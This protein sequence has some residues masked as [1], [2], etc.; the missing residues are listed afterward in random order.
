M[1]F[2]SA[3]TVTGVT[4]KNNIPLSFVFGSKRNVTVTLRKFTEA[5][6]KGKDPNNM[7]CLTIINKEPSPQV[8][9]L[10]ENLLKGNYGNDYLESE[11]QLD[12]KD[13]RPTVKHT[14]KPSTIP[15]ELISFSQ[16]ITRQ[17]NDYAKRTIQV[18]RWRLNASS[19]QNPFLN[20]W[21]PTWSFDGKTWTVLPSSEIMHASIK[22]DMLVA[23]ELMPEIVNLIN[24]GSDEPLAH[25]LLREAYDH[26]GTNPR[27]ALLTGIAAAEIGV[28]HLLTKLL[29]DT[30]W[31][32]ENL[33][34]P[35]IILILTQYFPQLLSHRKIKRKNLPVPQTI[36][37]TL[38]DGVALRNSVAH[39]GLPNIEFEKLDN[40][41]H[42]VENILW[43]LDYYSGLDWALN[44]MSPNIK[45]QFI[46]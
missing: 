29:P 32:L 14:D 13:G 19:R 3:Q 20:A 8:K 1:L 23:A 30:K 12:I 22:R 35:P 44:N 15:Q 17:L 36:I 42:S 27:S 7:L 40:I 37:D 18:L 9:I 46:T 45:S 31:V 11:W 26:Q 39:T 10:F 43:I 16:Q 5:E 24:K 34:S 4:V 38:K 28:K 33:P 21:F 41:L 2:Q 6:L 25:S